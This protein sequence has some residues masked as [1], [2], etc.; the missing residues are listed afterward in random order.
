MTVDPDRAFVPEAQEMRREM[1]D[2]ENAE[3]HRAEGAAS[4]LKQGADVVAA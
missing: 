4:S 3:R 1:P 2:R